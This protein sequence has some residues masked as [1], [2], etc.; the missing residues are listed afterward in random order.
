MNSPGFSFRHLVWEALRHC[1]NPRMESTY[2]RRADALKKMTD[3]AIEFLE[4]AKS[5]GA[6]YVACDSWFGNPKTIRQMKDL[7]YDVVSHIKSNFSYFFDNGL[8]KADYIRHHLDR[9]KEWCDLSEAKNINPN[10]EVLGSAKVTFKKGND[11]IRLLFCR[12]KKSK[13]QMKSP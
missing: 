6:Q 12:L 11:P 7:G 13:K 3:S 10:I 4:K 2:R 8:H 5:L 9:S 1:N